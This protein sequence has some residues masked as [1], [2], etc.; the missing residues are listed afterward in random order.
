MQTAGHED[1]TPG[2]CRSTCWCFDGLTAH[3]NDEGD[4]EDG[5]QHGGSRSILVGL[6]PE[7]DSGCSHECEQLAARI[8]RQEVVVRSAGASMDLQPTE[9]AKEAEK[10]NNSSMAAWQL[11]VNTGR[12][13]PRI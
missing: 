2:G 10:P 7:F 4:R 9:T 12:I 11:S 1:R 3:G 5:Q 8:A 13:G 6:D